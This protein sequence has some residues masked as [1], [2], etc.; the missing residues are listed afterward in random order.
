M[1]KSIELMNPIEGATKF[2]ERIENFKILHETKKGFFI[3]DLVACAIDMTEES[4]VATF[5]PVLI[6]DKDVFVREELIYGPDNKVYDTS[7]QIPD[8][9]M[10]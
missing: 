7:I 5:C 4:I 3:D 10:M 6:G 8:E 9:I 2:I 1:S